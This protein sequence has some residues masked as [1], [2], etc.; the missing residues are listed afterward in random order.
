M[1]NILQVTEEVGIALIFDEVYT[2]FRM[3]QHGATEYYGMGPDSGL[4]PD[5]IVYG[6]L[7]RF[8]VWQ[9][10]ALP[11]RASPRILPSSLPPFPRFSPSLMYPPFPGKTLG[12]GMPVG[13]VCGKRELMH[14]F[15]KK[16]PLR[17]NYIIG[18]F[19]AAP[20]TLGA[21]AEFL[22]WNAENKALYEKG[23]T[24]TEEFILS[25]NKEFIEQGE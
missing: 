19:S 12:G 21:M 7:A 5:M 8:D 13:V 9:H 17:V 6:E 25:C 20:M 18:T 24:K 16:H 10:L 23:Q 2:G 1:A 11:S 4:K 14:R 3:G 15:D 22:E